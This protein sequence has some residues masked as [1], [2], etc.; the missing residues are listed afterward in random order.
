MTRIILV[1]ATG[2]V[3]RTVLQKALSDPRV[4]QVVAPTRRPITPHPKLLNPV[5]DFDNLP[6][7]ASWWA[8]DAVICTLGTTR[9][10]AG[11]AEAFRRVDL[12]YPCAVARCAQ[13]AGVTCY[14]LNSSMGADASSRLLY[15][16]TKGEVENALRDMH[17]SSLAIVRPGLIGGDR[18]EFRV[19]EKVA[20]VVLSAL[21]PLLPRRFR[22]SPAS[23]IAYALIDSAVARTPGVA[24]IQADALAAD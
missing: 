15:P 5:V 1:G 19:G 10:T 4:T 13:Q 24:I 18:D 23:K 6:V 3:G 16:R 22:I 12:D 7:D 8:A 14:V 17:F 2:L 20:S 11:S 21:G 9:A